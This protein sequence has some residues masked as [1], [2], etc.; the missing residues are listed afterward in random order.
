MTCD[1]WA[2]DEFGDAELGDARR[3]ARLVR[4]AARVAE[5]PAGT[6]TGVFSVAAER[7]AAF[8]LVENDDVPALEI[9]AA[10]HRAAARRSVE[11][12][13]VFVPVDGTTLN[14]RDDDGR[15]ELGLISTRGVGAHGLQVMSAIAVLQDGTPIGICG[16]RYWARREPVGVGRHDYDPRTVEEKETKYWLEVMAQTETAFASEA[17]DTRPW[18]QADRG[19]DAW[20]V[21]LDAVERGVMITIRAAQDRRVQAEIDGQKEYL[22]PYLESQDV[23]GT[24]VLPVSAGHGRKAR[25]AFM[26][27]RWCRVTLLVRSRDSATRRPVDMWAVRT[28]EEGTTPRGEKAIDWLLLTTHPVTSLS[29]AALVL[30]GYA[31][32]WRIEDFHKVWKTSGCNV[33]DTQLE[34]RDHIERWA[35]VHASVAMRI[36]RLTHLGRGK[37]DE[38]A[39]VELAQAEIDAVILLQKPRGALRG[40]VPTIAEVTRWIADLGGYTGKSSGGPPGPKVIARGL[41]RLEPVAQVLLGGAKL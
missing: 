1:D 28:T 17:P 21:L 13:F 16:Q 32:R 35:T 40:T 12:D 14:I 37:P 39:T 30:L 29:A 38:P 19:A 4:V 15:K 41:R 2:R 7:E 24:Y 31:T 8:R 25:D 36:L 23:G 3:K 34:A 26:L 18:F 33:E 10:S 22:W 6:I 20:P 11:E 5:S 27:L 9:A